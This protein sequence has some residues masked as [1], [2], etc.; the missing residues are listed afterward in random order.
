MGQLLHKN[1]ATTQAVRRAI[2][3]NQESLMKA[4]K[5]SNAGEKDRE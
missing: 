1:A 5:R 4:A 2:Q 3:N